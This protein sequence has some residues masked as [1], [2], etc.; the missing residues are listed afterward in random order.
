MMRHFQMGKILNLK[1]EQKRK[2]CRK[3]ME[4][5]QDQHMLQQSL[6][7][8][9]ARKLKQRSIKTINNHVT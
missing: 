8:N 6:K 9:S 2:R 3:A 4:T 1:V 7:T 5:P